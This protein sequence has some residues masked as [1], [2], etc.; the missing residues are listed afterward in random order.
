MMSETR[1]YPVC[2]ECGSDD[3]KV[4]AFAEWDVERQKWVLSDVFDNEFCCDCDGETH[5]RWETE[6]VKGG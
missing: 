2:S 3:V 1:E 5:L 4:D 6:E